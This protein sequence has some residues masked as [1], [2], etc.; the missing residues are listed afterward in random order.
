[1]VHLFLVAVAHPR[2][3]FAAL[4]RYGVGGP[5]NFEFHVFLIF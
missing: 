1:M 4:P 3:T 5:G 2:A